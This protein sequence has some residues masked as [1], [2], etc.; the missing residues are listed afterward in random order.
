MGTLAEQSSGLQWW[1]V[2]EA[3]PGGSCCSS[4]TSGCS[5]SPGSQEGAMCPAQ[6]CTSVPLCFLQLSFSLLSEMLKELPNTSATT[7]QQKSITAGWS[8]SKPDSSMLLE[9]VI[10]LEPV[11]FPHTFLYLLLSNYLH[12]KALFL[13]YW[14]DRQIPQ[15]LDYSHF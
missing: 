9:W 13:M 4:L 7:F 12:P 5:G 15:F 3:V 11:M 6:C 14:S 1:G 2:E 8:V 10:G